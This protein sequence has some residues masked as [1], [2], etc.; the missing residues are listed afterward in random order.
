MNV[1][2]FPEHLLTRLK[3]KAARFRVALLHGTRLP[4]YLGLLVTLLVWLIFTSNEPVISAT[5]QRLDNVVYDQRFNMLTGT[6][7]AG[8]QKIVIVDYDER[9]LAAEGQWPWSRFKLADLVTQLADL[10]V[11]VVGFDV[12]FPEYDRNLAVELNARIDDDPDMAAQVGALMSELDTDFLRNALDADQAFAESMSATDVVLGF[13]FLNVQGRRSGVLPPPLFEMEPAMAERLTLAEQQGH[14]ANVDVLQNAASG[15]GFF[16]TVP[17]VDGVIRRSPLFMRFRDQL[18]PAL[19]LEMARLYYFEDDFT[20]EPDRDA[21]GRIQGLLGIKMGNILIPTDD[22]GRVAVPYIGPVGSYPYISAT[23]VLR[24]TLTD[25]QKELLF[26]S[27]VLV[28]TT[29]VG[30]Y[31]LRATPVGAVYPGVEVHANVLNAI[32]NSSPEIVIGGDASA[33]QEQGTMSAIQAELRKAQLNPF[34]SRPGWEEGAIIT[35]IIV[36]GLVLSVVYP[37]LGPALLAISSLTFL[38][39]LTALNFHLWSRYNLDISLVILWLLVI[40]IAMVNMTYG[41]L[42]EGLN[43]KVIKSMFDQY[44]PPAH[45]DAMLSNPDKYNFAGESKELSVLFSDIRNFTTISEKLTAIELKSMLNEFFTPITGIIFEHN[46]TIDKYVGDMVMAF[47]GAPLD[48]PNHRMHAVQAALKMLAKVEELKPLFKEKGLPEVNIGVGINSGM[49]S[50]GDMGSTYRRAYTVL[51]DA[52]NL[53]S[54]LEGITKAYGVALLIGEQTY[55]GISGILCRQVDKVQVKGKEEPI[56]IYQPLCMLDEAST[57]L[58]ALVEDYHRAYGH[59]LKQE[60]DA[61]E[62]LFREVRQRDPD[63]QLYALYL[64]RIAVLRMQRLPQNW[65]GTWRHTSK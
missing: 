25:A 60:W 58:K 37:H 39:G 20:L 46:G 33:Q 57:E 34:P 16:D 12:F 18:Y 53:G 44:V 2:I 11:L 30:L 65:D 26:N 45:I 40:L 28:G 24:G 23:D 15:A 35:S 56:C 6:Q 31:D 54:R 48:D 50:V 36:I 1:G 43:K 64:E 8:Q 27:L 17:D 63:T 55:A 32:L 4:T 7:R 62:R 59:Y 13:S 3:Q 52:V 61:A 42:R 29:S 19:A 38:L 10:G 41:F 14:I 22:Q 49:M 5:L 21:T 51:G 9:S 47:W